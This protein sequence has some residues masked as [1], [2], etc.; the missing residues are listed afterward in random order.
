MSPI[1]TRSLSDSLSPFLTRDISSFSSLPPVRSIHPPLRGPLSPCTPLP[2][3]PLRP[4]RL[5]LTDGLIFFRRKKSLVPLAVQL[6]LP[7]LSPLGLHSYLSSCGP[8]P[9]ACCL[10]LCSCPCFR[11]QAMSYCSWFWRGQEQV[12]P[13]LQ[14]PVHTALTPLIPPSVHRSFTPLSPSSISVS[15]WPALPLVAGLSLPELP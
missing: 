2:L 11:T 6:P 9:S 3:V 14:L 10:C 8:S 5:S 7:D 12:F 4:C 13:S 1:L 15:I